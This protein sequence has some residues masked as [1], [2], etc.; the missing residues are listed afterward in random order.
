[1]AR[2]VS[3]QIGAPPSGSS[4]RSTEVMTA[5]TS[6]MRAMASATRSG[7]SRSTRAGAPGEHG[8]E[9][10]RPGADVA[11]DHEG[12]R[13]GRPALADVR[14]VGALA[15]GVQAVARDDAARLRELR[16][17]RQAHPQPLRP[18]PDRGPGGVGVRHPAAPAV[19]ISAPAS[20][21]ASGL[22]HASDPPARSPCSR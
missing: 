9:A 14:A 3:A 8:A 12:R 15:D 4:S 10:A 1:M 21:L 18:A 16:P 22:V 13:P 7:S 5:W 6:P 17:L 20:G 11:E 2:I 19:A